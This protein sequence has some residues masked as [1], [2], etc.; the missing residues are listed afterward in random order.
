MPGP[1][2]VICRCKGTGVIEWGISIPTIRGFT[3]GGNRGPC[4]ACHPEIAA[5]V[6]SWH[7]SRVWPADAVIGRWG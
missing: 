2:P 7:R 5:S 1:I 4:P 6:T 3:Y